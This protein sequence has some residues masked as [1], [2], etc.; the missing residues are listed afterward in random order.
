MVR[1]SWHATCVHKISLNSPLCGDESQAIAKEFRA[2]CTPNFLLFDD[3]R[4]L[5]YRGQFDNS[6]PGNDK[7][8][9]DADP[10]HAIDAV[11]AGKLPPGD[12]KP[13][14]G[15]NIKWK[16]GNEPEYFGK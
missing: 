7:P 5:V 8:A 14:V 1:L 9:T 15:C 13:S 12:Q 6:R 4:E 3:K 16:S 2:A 11:L 10:R